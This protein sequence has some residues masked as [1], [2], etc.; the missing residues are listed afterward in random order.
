MKRN[1]LIV[2]IALS[3]ILTGLQFVFSTADA[4][5]DRGKAVSVSAL[6]FDLKNINVK[7]HFIPSSEK[8]AGII[9]EMA[10]TVVVL[11]ADTKQAYFAVQGDHIYKPDI[12]F[13]LDNSKCRIK[14]TT[15][16]IITM[17]SNAKI[18]I[19]EYVDD[20]RGKSKKTAFNMM[21]GKA[22]FYVVKLFRYKK[23]KSRVHTPTAVCGVRGTKFGVEIVEESG[24][25]AQNMPIY[26]ADASDFG[27]LYL[28][29]TG[30]GSSTKVFFYDGAG[31]LCD[32]NGNNCFNVYEGQSGLVDDDGNV[33]VGIA[34]TEAA[35]DFMMET[36]VSG[37]TEG[38]RSDDD[39]D[40][41]DANDGGDNDRG[42]NI[43]IDI[44]DDRLNSTLD[45]DDDDDDDFDLDPNDDGGDGGAGTGEGELEF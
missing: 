6:P 4:P 10:G 3:F 24:R 45:D 29:Q 17:G 40:D 20:R 13:T 35:N 42:G 30:S 22:M 38:D 8:P 14:F 21:R 31:E 26:L 32:E 41:D 34:D 12:F 15:A 1:I 23:T 19:S 28:A 11:H 25:S 44:N 18:S 27:F 43:S 39:D 2:L 33:Y 16:D 37:G 36:E 9:H 5:P 7:D